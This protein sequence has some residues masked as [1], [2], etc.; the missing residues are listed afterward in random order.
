M[1]SDS[2]RKFLQQAATAGIAYSTNLS[3][4]R[5][6][7][8]QTPAADSSAVARIYIDFRRTIR[9]LDRNMFGSVAERPG[10]G[11]YH[12]IYEPGASLSDANAFPKVL[13]E[14]VR[15]LEVPIIRYPGG[16]YV[17]G[18]NWLAGVGPKKDRPPML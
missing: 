10:R 4:S 9:A 17:S 18:F 14:A 13:L 16:K 1:F 7:Q 5:F 6:A 15:H 11:S 3:G 12:R 2:R 8:A